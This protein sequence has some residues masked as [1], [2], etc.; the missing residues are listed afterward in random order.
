MTEIILIEDGNK[1]ISVR[2]P[3]AVS[4]NRASRVK[5]LETNELVEKLSKLLYIA[6]VKVMVPFFLWPVA[7]FCFFKYF[8]SDLGSEALLISLPLW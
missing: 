5:Y 4:R 3:L 1:E 2:S 6:F 8:T 7:L